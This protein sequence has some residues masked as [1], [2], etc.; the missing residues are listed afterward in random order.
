MEEFVVNFSGKDE[1]ELTPIDIVAEI[2]DLTYDQIRSCSEI[3][4]IEID[5]DI[6]E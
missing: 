2:T 3:V 1:N 5:Y 6:P 4:E